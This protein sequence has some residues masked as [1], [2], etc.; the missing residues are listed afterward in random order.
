MYPPEVIPINPCPLVRL[1]NPLID[2][3][4]ANARVGRTNPRIPG[5]Y[6]EFI[7]T[8]LQG[9][10]VDASGASVSFLFSQINLHHL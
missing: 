6:L 1:A 2:D 4:V 8:H 10:L 9:R 5:D 3:E 7:T